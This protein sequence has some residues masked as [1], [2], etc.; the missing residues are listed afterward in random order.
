MNNT[1]SLTIPVS[2]PQLTGN[3]KTY[4]LECLDTGWVSS[5]GRFVTQFEQDFAKLVG[6]KHAISVSNGT[7]A[8]HLALLAAGIGPGDEVLV[9]NLTFAATAN[10]VI[11]CGATPVLTDV[12]QL[13]WAIDLHDAAKRIT[14]RTRAIIPV[15]LYGVPADMV[16]IKA[17]A[18]QHQLC[19]IE[20]CAESLGASVVGQATGSI[21][22]LGCFSFFA[23]KLITT[24]EGGMVTTNNDELADTVRCLRDH[25]M[26]PDKR[27][28]HHIAGLNYR[29]TNMQAALGVAQLEQYE[30]FLNRR[31]EVAERY[32]Q[33]LSDLPGLNWQQVYKDTSPVCWLF[34][35]SLNPQLAGL[36]VQ[37]LAMVLA[38]EGIETRPFFFPLHRQPPYF[39]D[40]CY[41][42]SNWLADNGLSLPT[43]TAL[44]NAQID[45]ITCRIRA[46][47]SQQ[48]SKHE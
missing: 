29:M 43:Y 44:S 11:H 22:D 37:E 41:P 19:V 9:P 4:L 26:K 1:P 2:E 38:S 18:R 6:T 47:L 25:G 32:R 48:G 5:K 16:N 23:N 42:I 3:A 7:A 24:G 39:Q 35:F 14:D 28:W 45:H 33:G 21:G 15:H 34:S 27:Y 46:L 10:A 8:L 20:D 30:V 36:T 40:E 12:C 31:A 17:F 13:S